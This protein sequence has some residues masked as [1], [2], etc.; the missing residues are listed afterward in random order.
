MI[1]SANVGQTLNRVGINPEYVV[2]DRDSFFELSPCGNGQS[3]KA[4]WR[5]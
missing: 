3:G 5:F 4:S 1:A 2:C